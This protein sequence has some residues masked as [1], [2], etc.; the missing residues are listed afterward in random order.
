MDIGLMLK[1]YSMLFSIVQGDKQL[2]PVETGM[3]IGIV[4][5]FKCILW[6]FAFVQ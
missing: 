3:N 1:Q 2:S 4:C 5:V 6:I